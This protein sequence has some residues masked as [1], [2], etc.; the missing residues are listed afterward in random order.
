MSEVRFEHGAG[1]AGA[2]HAGAAVRAVHGDGAS[3]WPSVLVEGDLARARKEW[4]HTNGA[5]AYASSTLACM[6]SRRYH[7][8]LVA[9]L[10]PPRGRHVLLSHMDATIARPRGASP[11][12]ASRPWSRPS[13][14]LAKHQFPG[15]DPASGPFHLHRFD[16]DPLP[17]WTYAVPGGEL[18]ITLALVRGENALV[19]RYVWRG[20]EPVELTLRPLLAARHFHQLQREHGGM[21]QRV[22]LRP[23]LPANG[24]PH[25][26]A[27]GE[28]RVQPR[29]ELPRVC[30]R[31]EGTFVG[32]PDWW[33]RFEY[34]AER[35]RG[36]EYEEDLWTPGVFE[37]AI[38]DRPRWLVAA[39]EK[40][41]AGEPEA[42]LEATR[43]ALLAEDPGPSAPMLERRLT[44][45]AETFRADLARRPGVLAG[46]PWFEVWG[47]DTLAALPGLYLVPKKI[48]AALRVLRDMI[49]AMKDGLVP[50]R[51]PEAG[52]APAPDG[53]PP[54]SR[55]RFTEPYVSEAP[56][57]DGAD[58]TLWLFEAARHVA[59]TLGDRHPFVADELAPALRDA[60]EAAL[61]GTTNGAHVTA[62]GLFAAG[63]PGDA[64]TWMAARVGG[65]PVTPRAGCPVELT[66]LWARGCDTL[67]RL[68]RAGGDI[69]L[70]DRAEAACRR[71][72]VAFRDRF[73]CDE[74]GYPFDVISEA[75]EG[76]GA[77][78][79]AS[80]RPNAV[81]ALAVDPECFSP[82]QAAS[83]LDR[84]RRELVTR[85]GL[86]TLAPGD[87]AYVGRYTGGPATRDAAYHQGAA[88]PW[89]L[90]FYV[91][92]ALESGPEGA[93]VVPLLEALVASAA[94]NELAV[95]LVPELADGD[96]P[97]A[98]RGSIAQAWSVAEL[99]RALAWDL[100]RKDP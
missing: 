74:K 91:R 19:L 70:H 77:F 73:W 31:Y 93:Q 4:L 66:A 61:R 58:A 11:P 81:V 85:A 90:G 38:D 44:I 27:P 40:L 28:M 54:P 52:P 22:E 95:G 72:R 100:P 76:A 88:W 94:E 89:L 6:H 29:R 96:P 78:R 42:L 2:V 25:A 8:L 84:A 23:G 87:P 46:Y 37:V 69:P 99:L 71:A 64:L 56:S 82:E 83:I 39:V 1:A 47:R 36:L 21:V 10:D 43:A 79:D 59:D 86:R 49:G 98:P 53:A 18:E 92:A 16:Q 34:L 3:P 80:I 5:G 65:K 7:G 41:P 14:G 13:W 51:I 48:D 62:D 20:R 33:R 45:A 12:P 63:A 97:H 9:A 55:A 17:R 30:F 35:D 50:S 26:S 24:A 15:L 57:Y 75:R 32:S 60:F 67:A 68:A